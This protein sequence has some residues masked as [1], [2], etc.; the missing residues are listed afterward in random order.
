M[1]VQQKTF[2]E[3]KDGEVIIN[4][5]KYQEISKKLK[6]KHYNK[7]NWNHPIIL[8]II[9]LNPQ[10]CMR[11]VVTMLEMYYWKFDTYEEFIK[12]LEIYLSR[13]VTNVDLMIDKLILP[14]EVKGYGSLSNFDQ[15]IFKD[16]LFNW[17]SRWEYPERH[18][19]EQVRCD[20]DYLRVDMTDGNWYHV[21]SADVWW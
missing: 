16:F 19:P 9:E 7:L 14:Y 4:S 6:V 11:K 17:Y 13:D 2:W 10:Y 12:Y 18:Q 8:K 3:V 15:G 1:L 20:E 5:Q 21:R